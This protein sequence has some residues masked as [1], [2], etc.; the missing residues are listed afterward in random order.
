MFTSRQKSG[1]TQTWIQLH[2]VPIRAAADGLHDP[3]VAVGLR[4]QVHAV[5]RLEV[6]GAVGSRSAPVR[7][8][9]NDDL[10][11]LK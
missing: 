7:G 2:L 10:Q 8:L 5:V 4:A 9:V 11:F 6:A 3:V 1:L